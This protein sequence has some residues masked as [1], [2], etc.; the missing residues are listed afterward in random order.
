MRIK[1]GALLREMMNS[2]NASNADVGRAAG[3][4]RSLIS[5]LCNERRTTCTPETA[6]RIAAYFQ[7]PVEV[8]FVPRTSAAS[9]QNLKDGQAA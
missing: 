5:A 9:G 7:V 1:S 2:R 3:Q 6:E 8:L 4:D